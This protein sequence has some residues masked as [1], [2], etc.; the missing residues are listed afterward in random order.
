MRGRCLDE[1]RRGGWYEGEKAHCQILSLSP[2]EQC[3]A[4]RHLPE[5][6][7]WHLSVLLWLK[8]RARQPCLNTNPLTG[9]SRWLRWNE[10][11]IRA[12]ALSLCVTLRGEIDA[13]PFFAPIQH[14]SCGG[15]SWSEMLMEFRQL[16]LGTEIHLH[17]AAKCS[18]NIIISLQ[19]A[20]WQTA[21]QSW[22]ATYWLV[23]L[24]ADCGTVCQAL[25]SALIKPYGFE[26]GDEVLQYVFKSFISRFFTS[27]LA[28]SINPR[29]QHLWCLGFIEQDTHQNCPQE[30]GWI[31]DFTYPL[32]EFTFI[33]TVYHKWFAWIMVP[34]H[35]LSGVDLHILHSSHR[36]KKP[37]IPLRSW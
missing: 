20:G 26:M 16:Q 19:T 6:W 32:I 15:I 27:W 28:C 5:R 25:L 12:V 7:L 21:V 29:H 17:Y 10:A 8:C 2:E 13:L 11:V 3:Q 37:D 31:V 9:P 36:E 18:W 14:S 30:R 33:H 34:G 1:R 24:K 4:P 35:I 23:I 22:T